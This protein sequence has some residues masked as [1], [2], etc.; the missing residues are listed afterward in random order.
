[1]W[2][3]LD[4]GRVRKIH[5]VAIQG[6]GSFDQWVTSYRVEYR[7]NESDDLEFAINAANHQHVSILIYNFIKFVSFFFYCQTK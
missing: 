6:R 1:M 4:I 3:Q 5:G 7:K 2:I